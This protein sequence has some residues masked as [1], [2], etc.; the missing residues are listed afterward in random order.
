MTKRA[1]VA[2]C[3]SLCASTLLFAQGPPANPGP[4]G[5][6]PQ[7]AISSAIVNNATNVMHATGANLCTAPTVKLN[8]VPLTATNA[9]ASAFDVSVAGVSPGSYSLAVSCGAAGTAN[10]T[11][12]VTIGAVGPQGPQGIQ[13]P[14]GLQ[15]IQG[16]QGLKGDT[17]ATGPQ[18]PQGPKGD[19]GATGPQ[20]PP[21][22]QGATGPQGPPGT[23]STA[24][25]QVVLD[26]NGV[27]VG[28]VVGTAGVSGATIRY[29]VLGDSVLL[30]A[31]SSGLTTFG[32]TIQPAVNASQAKVLFK[33]ANCSGDAYLNLLGPG[34]TPT[35]LLTPR[36]A[37]ILGILVFGPLQPPPLGSACPVPAGGSWLYVT[38]PFSCPVN[39]FAGPTALIG[40]TSYYSQTQGPNGNCAPLNS[41]EPLGNFVVYHRTDDLASKFTPPFYVPAN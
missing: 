37:L 16:P 6:A 17:G 29:F 35:A 20:G 3:L 22:P 18:G 36:Q 27:V 12:D 4:G 31:T 32:G 1:A 11:F 5:G 34:V 40:L 39:N 24:P 21:G 14:Q 41:P 13:G 26:K 28:S 15:G 30:S 2:V 38:D 10:A 33:E 23:T 8:G 25:P 7:A 9:S 19:T